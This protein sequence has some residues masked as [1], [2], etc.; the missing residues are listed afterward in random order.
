MAASNAA[1]SGWVRFNPVLPSQLPTAELKT[2]YKPLGT[3]PTTAASGSASVLELIKMVAV[4]F[5]GWE[6]HQGLWSFEP[7]AHTPNFGWLFLMCASDCCTKAIAMA[8]VH[9]SVDL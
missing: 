3:S 8:D 5:R 9:S 7:S 2:H 1:T 6:P 4:S